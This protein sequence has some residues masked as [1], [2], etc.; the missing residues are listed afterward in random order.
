MCPN[1]FSIKTD[2]GNMDYV[3][4]EGGRRVEQRWDPTE[5]G[6]IVPDDKL[7]GRK[8]ADDAMYKLEHQ[9]TDKDKSAD[10]APRIH[11]ISQI[12]D[13]VKD[14][15]LANRVLRDQFRAKKKERKVRLE[16]DKKLL[17]KS[18]L[19]LDLVDEREEDVRMA[20]LMNIQ[21]RTEAEE[22][23]KDQRGDIEEGD[24]FGSKQLRKMSS[25]SERK[26]F[27]VKTVSKA[28]RSKQSDLLKKKGFGLV[29]SRV[30]E[31]NMD[32]L[33]TETSKVTSV[34]TGGQQKVTNTGI[35]H[36]RSSTIASSPTSS[37]TVVSPPAVSSSNSLSLL[38]CEYSDTEEEDSEND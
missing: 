24:I 21:A 28:A 9:T 22:K 2:P 16:E 4:E 14:D 5:N 33:D 13:R 1:H 18:G 11:H 23:Q 38:S 25:S 8:L 20:M 19:E 3:I 32:S 12:Q 34:S 36:S 26:L 29:V 30:K 37:T 15:Y 7:V 10:A 17:S 35:T 31:R 27:A 6:Q